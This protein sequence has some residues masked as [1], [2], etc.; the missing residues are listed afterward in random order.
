MNELALLK[1]YVNT[2]EAEN[3]AKNNERDTLY[4]QLQQFMDENYNLASQLNS[5]Q[6]IRI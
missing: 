4:Q 6:G 5:L 3:N 2:L 1:E